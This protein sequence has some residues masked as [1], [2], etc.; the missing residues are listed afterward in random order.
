MA[1]VLFNEI[2]VASCGVTVTWQAALRLLPSCVVAVMVAVPTAFAVTK[3]LL[4]TLATLV[5]LDVHDTDWLVVLLGDTVALSCNV[6]SI[7][8]L[9]VV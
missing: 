5:L 1:E 7:T 3:P 6:L 2:P 9:A 4:F 8:M